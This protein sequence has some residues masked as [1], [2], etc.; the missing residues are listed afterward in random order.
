MN[1]QNKK[2]ID[3]VWKNGYVWGL[4]LG[5]MLFLRL[6]T[7]TLLLI[8]D[9]LIADPSFVFGEYLGGVT[10]MIIIFTIR[11]LIIRRIK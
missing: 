4:A 11:W 9:D 6:I 5:W 1:K 10:V 7:G 3:E 8:D 2:W